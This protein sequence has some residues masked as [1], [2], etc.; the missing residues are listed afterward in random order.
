MR[1]HVRNAGLDVVKDL[2]VRL[3]P[4]TGRYYSALAN[5]YVTTFEVSRAQRSAIDRRQTDRQTLYEYEY[6]SERRYT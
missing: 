2:Q 1:D 3:D 6:S 4:Y 5:I